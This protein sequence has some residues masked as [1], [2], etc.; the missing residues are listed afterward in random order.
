MARH[1]LLTVS[2]AMLAITAACAQDNDDT[3]TSVQPDRAVTEQ[4][5]REYIL[6][7]PEIIE[8]AFIALQQKREF[9]AA[10]VSRAAIGENSAR[11]VSA[12]ADYSI[13]PD[14]APVTVV[15]FFDYRCGPC[16][17][18]METIN[19]LPER[20]NG[21]VRVVFKEFPILSAESRIAA[22]ATL[23]A[24][25]QGKY[26]EMHRALMKSPSRFTDADIVKIA[27]EIGLDMDRWTADRADKTLDRQI[28]S[29]HQLAVA[30]GANATPTFV[31]GDTMF[32]GLKREQLEAL[33]IDGIAKAG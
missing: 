11:L 8:E 4:I 25:R 24:G 26:V 6:S 19:A 27:A 33:I 9:E 23:A 14:D 13:G 21:K 31:V 32:S 7:N 3:A 1:L 18:S 2:I 16:R 22:V 29:N 17:A 30:I 15:E 12:P 5:I 20:Y 10:E 28:D